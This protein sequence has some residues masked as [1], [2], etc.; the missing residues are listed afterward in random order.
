MATVWSVGTLSFDLKIPHVQLESIN[1]QAT[2]KDPWEADK[3]TVW[4]SKR[5]VAFLP[6]TIPTD[7][8]TDRLLLLGTI[9]FFFFISGFNK[10]RYC[11]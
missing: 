4:Y 3:Q 5:F 7:K 2:S 6:T 10:L 8:T 1:I 11:N 9:I